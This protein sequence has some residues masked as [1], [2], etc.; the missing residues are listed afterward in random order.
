MKKI[1]LLFLVFFTVSLFAEVKI[2]MSE[3]DLLKEKEKPDGKTAIGSKAIYRW[4]DMEVRV[5][6]GKITKITPRDIKKEEESEERR[7]QIAE[8]KRREEEKKRYEEAQIEAARQARLAGE[9]MRRAEREE[10][11]RADFIKDQMKVRTGTVT[12]QGYTQGNALAD[13]MSKLPPRAKTVGSPVYI[14]KAQVWTCNL[15]YEVRG[16]K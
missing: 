7:T 16:T 9:R 1:I 15:N 14:N 8:Q 5:E 10:D 11:E 2:G 6:D 12:G 3:E 13:A 4:P